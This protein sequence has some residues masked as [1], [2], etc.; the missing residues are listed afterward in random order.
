M[1]HVGNFT[2]EFVMNGD[3]LLS[4]PP[5]DLDKPI[6]HYSLGEY[7]SMLAYHRASVAEHTHKIEALQHNLT[8]MFP[9]SEVRIKRFGD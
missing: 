2:V 7:V 3:Q 9:V 6:A 4:S 5:V 1:P 8:A